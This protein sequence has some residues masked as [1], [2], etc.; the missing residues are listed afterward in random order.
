MTARNMSAAD[1]HRQ[2]TEVYG[3]EVMHVSQVQKWARKFKD[4]RTNFHEEE[5]SDRFFVITDDLTQAV[6]TKI[7]ENMRFPMT[8]CSLEFLDVSQSV[9]YKIVTEDLHFKKLC[10]RWVPRLLTAKHK[11]KCSKR[12]ALSMDFLIR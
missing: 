4:W 12:S 5:R 10:S 7:R 8:T 3:T 9:V 11:E 2:I 1:I 6:E